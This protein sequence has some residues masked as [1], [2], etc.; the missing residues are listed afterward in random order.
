MGW[1]GS[2]PHPY[3]TIIFIN[4]TELSWGF[5]N[6]VTVGLKKTFFTN[7]V[8]WMVAG[9]ASYS[10]SPYYFISVRVLLSVSG[11]VRNPCLT[12]IHV[13]VPSLLVDAF[14]KISLK[15]T[16]VCE[17]CMSLTWFWRHDNN[18]SLNHDTG[19]VTIYQLGLAWICNCIPNSCPILLLF[20]A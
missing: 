15:S 9:Y 13:H 7:K 14:L 8:V 18:V 3:C 5:L 19:E 10:K 1:E 17:S 11:K 16:H 4:P 2:R 12:D 20:N 6:W